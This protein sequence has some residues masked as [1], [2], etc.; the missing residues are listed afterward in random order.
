M[1]LS[2]IIV[3]LSLSLPLSLKSLKPY[4]WVKIKKE[5]QAPGSQGFG[6][7]WLT[8]VCSEQGCGV[9]V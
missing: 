6:S 1:F 7:V 3:S 9:G 8:A 5:K 2:H 4:P